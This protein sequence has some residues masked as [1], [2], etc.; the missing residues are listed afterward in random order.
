MTWF[1]VPIRQIGI[2]AE[3]WFGLRILVQCRIPEHLKDIAKALKDQGVPYSIAVYPVYVGPI[4]RGRQKTVRLADRPE[5]VRAIV[6]M[7]DG[8]AT[9]VLHGYSHQFGNRKNPLSGE[10]G[11]DYEF[12]LAHLDSR[13]NVVYEGPVPGDSQSWAEDRLDQ[14][15]G[16]TALSR[17]AKA[18]PFQRPTLCS[19]SR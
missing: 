2:G 8:G 11:A 14:A 15:L 16:R 13:G 3:R 17:P 12:F 7:L 10:S 9:L 4:I 19:I 5:V 6:E 1:L 18:S